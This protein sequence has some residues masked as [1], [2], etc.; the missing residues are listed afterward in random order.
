MPNHSM[1]MPTECFED[2]C[3]EYRSCCASYTGFRNFHVLN[4]LWGLFFRVIW[5]VV[6]FVYK[7]LDSTDNR[8][9]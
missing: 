7:F 1:R 4:Q 8:M 5:R 3:D 2:K 9:N 6:E